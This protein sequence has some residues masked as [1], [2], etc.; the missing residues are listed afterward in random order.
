M[1]GSYVV[2]AALSITDEARPYSY[3]IRLAAFLIIIAG[4]IDKN[5]TAAR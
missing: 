2:L 3:V 4:I 5:R 1:V